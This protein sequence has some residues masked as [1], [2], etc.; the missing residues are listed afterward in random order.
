MTDATPAGHAFVE[1]TPFP[2][3]GVSDVAVRKLA[4]DTKTTLLMI[5]TRLT[6]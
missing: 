3:Y 6:W 1:Q 2:M 4:G 5:G